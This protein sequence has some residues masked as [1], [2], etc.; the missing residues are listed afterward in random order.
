MN[1]NKYVDLFGFQAWQLELGRAITGA[2]GEVEK[3]R[4]GNK[5]SSTVVTVDDFQPSLVKAYALGWKVSDFHPDVLLTS[6]VK[7]LS[8]NFLICKGEMTWPRS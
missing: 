3:S 7:Q 4:F 8:L 2:G 5:C 1:T 6:N